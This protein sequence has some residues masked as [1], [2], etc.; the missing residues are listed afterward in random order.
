MAVQTI[1]NPNEN[2]VSVAVAPGQTIAFDFD[3]TTASFE[4]TGNDLTISLDDGGQVVLSNFFVAADMGGLPPLQLADGTQV[5]SGDFLAAFDVDVTP[6]AGAVPSSG[7]NSYDDGAGSLIGGL[8]LSDSLGNTQWSGAT[9]AG[10]DYQG[11]DVAAAPGL[12]P[13]TPETTEDRYLAVLYDNVTGPGAHPYTFN[14]NLP[15]AADDAILTII[16]SQAGYVDM[17][18][19]TYADGK[20][21]LQVSADGRS[22]MQTDGTVY[23]E[24]VV[25]YNGTQYTITVA[26]TTDGSFSPSDAGDGFVSEWYTDGNT[27]GRS[28]E[29]Y[30]TG[31]DGATGEVWLQGLNAQNGHNNLYQAYESTSAA[32]S[33]IHVSSGVIAS[34]T[35]SNTLTTGLEAESGIDIHANVKVSGGAAN[36]ITSGN[37][38]VDAGS[39]KGAVINSGGTNTLYAGFDVSLVSESSGDSNPAYGVSADFLGLYAADNTITAGENI[40]IDVTAAGAGSDAIGLYASGS[41]A[42]NTLEAGLTVTITTD[43][44][45][46]ESFAM[47]AKDNG[48]NVIT[49]TGGADG[50]TGGEVNLTGDIYAATGGSNEIH[51]SAGDDVFRLNGAVSDADALIIHGAGGTDTLVLMAADSAEFIS[52][53]SAWLADSVTNGTIDGIESIDVELGSGLSATDFDDIYDLFDGLGYTVNYLANSDFDFSTS[54]HA[55]LAALGDTI[56]SGGLGEQSVNIDGLENNSTYD[57]NLSD[58]ADSLQG[59]EHIDLSGGNNNVLTIDSLLDGLNIDTSLDAS[60]ITNNTSSLD[61]TSGTALLITGDG[62]GDQVSITGTDWSG[63]GSVTYNG[64]DYNVYTNSDSSQFL[65]IQ[66]GLI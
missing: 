53:Y 61:L 4:R 14:I 55:D 15:G 19:L 56:I 27:A 51:G 5:D 29:I 28:D 44:A 40:F 3:L 38:T 18:T 32:A 52:N 41:D 33:V 21:T 39:D 22:A 30:V 50:T 23:D 46:G 36:T 6:A 35:G 31:N 45:G 64:I 65:L 24:I 26:L 43:S 49:L 13:D 60:N 25:E 9:A 62:G 11:I 37:I 34:G 66:T 63:S 8:G 1:H 10:E 7:I 54:A 20:W 42:V 47:Y 59:F 58:L 16:S 2:V 57:Y 12:T 48:L 17:G